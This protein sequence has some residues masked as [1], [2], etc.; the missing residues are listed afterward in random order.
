MKLSFRFLVTF[1]FFSLLLTSAV[2]YSQENKPQAE[3]VDSFE[4]NKVLIIPFRQNMYIS[5]S[6]KEIL[7]ESKIT[8][9]QLV[10]RFRS[11][12]AI[13]VRSAVPGWW[14]SELFFE[15][16][17]N[18]S[19]F[20]YQLF[21]AS[22]KYKYEL[23]DLKTSGAK[24]PLLKQKNDEKEKPGI[25]QGQ[26]KIEQDTRPKFMNVTLKNDTVI[27]Y[28][29][30]KSDADYFLF[31]NQLDIK[32]DLSDY[33]ANSN[34]TFMRVAQVHYTILNKK[35]KQFFAGLASFSFSAKTNDSETIINEVFP[36]V[37]SRIVSHLPAPVPV[38]KKKKSL[39]NK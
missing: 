36:Q 6:D 2:S 35:G 15:K 24:T 4:I 7:E 25:S 21:D 9:P 38:V 26:I 14:E 19:L 37:A 22:L 5:D 31:L 8:F 23:L 3:K 33:V 16:E 20:L 34:R 18:D 32:S 13:A 30:E 39:F 29:A 17:K 11:G 12:L 28:L 10:S 27:P 1:L